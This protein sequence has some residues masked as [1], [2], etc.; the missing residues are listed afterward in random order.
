M[1]NPIV[2]QYLLLIGMEHQYHEAEQEAKTSIYHQ[3]SQPIGPAGLDFE[4]SGG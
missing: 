4:W 3:R 1:R 2:A